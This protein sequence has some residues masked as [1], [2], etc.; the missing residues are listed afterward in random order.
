MFDKFNPIE[1]ASIVLSWDI[2][3]SSFA[4]A[5]NA[6]ATFMAGIEHEQAIESGLY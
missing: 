3:E 1:A 2:P 5:L 6:Q 4:F